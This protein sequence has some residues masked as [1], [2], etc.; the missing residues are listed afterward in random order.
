MGGK[1]AQGVSR[2]GGGSGEQGCVMGGGD[3]L[4][5]TVV[6]WRGKSLGHNVLKR[7]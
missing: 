4:G 5:K 7:G 1:H 6:G 2:F 3:A